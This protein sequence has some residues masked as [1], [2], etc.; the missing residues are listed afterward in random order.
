MAAGGAC[1]GIRSGYPRPIALWP[2]TP[3]KTQAIAYHVFPR[4]FST[5]A[6][7]K[8]KARDYHDYM[9]VVFAE[10][11]EMVQSLQR[12]MASRY[13]APGRMAK[14]EMA[15]HHILNHY[16]ERMFGTGDPANA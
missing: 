4:E 12:A 16:F 10:D 14:L 5:T 13:F 2:L 3:N 8:D 1:R 11:L 15:I 6:D 7:F 9:R